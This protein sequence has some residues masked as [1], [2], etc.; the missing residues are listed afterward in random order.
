M[1]SDLGRETG[2][3]QRFIFQSFLDLF[4]LVSGV[5]ELEATVK[6]ILIVFKNIADKGKFYC[7]SSK[8]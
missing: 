7:L 2:E 8:F 5:F 3:K 4:F 6:I 1:L